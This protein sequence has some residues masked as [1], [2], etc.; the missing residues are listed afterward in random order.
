MI[1]HVKRRPFLAPL[2]RLAAIT[3]FA[4]R[5]NGF[6]PPIAS[7]TTGSVVGARDPW[8]GG[9]LGASLTS[10][11]SS[12]SI[13]HNHR[14]A[15]RDGRHERA[16]AIAGQR[17]REVGVSMAATS[18]GRLGPGK[19]TQVV[20]LRHGMSTFNKLNIFTVSVLAMSRGLVNT[21]Q[22]VCIDRHGCA[23]RTCSY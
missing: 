22:S 19:G 18:A 17:T 6:L 2:R 13:G 14:T 5:G 9:H 10:S 20:L 16:R 7:S 4:T 12:E 15:R 1:P 3:C 21:S 8:G 23:T 11:T